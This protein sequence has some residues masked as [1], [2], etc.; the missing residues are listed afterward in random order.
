MRNSGTD[1]GQSPNGVVLAPF[2]EPGDLEEE[3][4]CSRTRQSR[5]LLR[6]APQGAPFRESDPSKPWLQCLCE[7]EFPIQ[8]D[9]ESQ[10]HESG[11]ELEV[12]NTFPARWQKSFRYE[13]GIMEVFRRRGALEQFFG[14]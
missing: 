10:V 6:V 1:L 4:P 9:K 2:K 12:P 5:G 11:D 7:T 3:K 13:A 8:R 14:D